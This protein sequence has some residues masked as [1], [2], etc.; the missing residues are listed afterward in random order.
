LGDDLGLARAWRRVASCHEVACRFRAAEEA[1]ERALVHAR[2][3]GSMQE[4]A[5]TIDLL[6]T[7][8]VFG[9][10][11]AEQAIARCETFLAE[12]GSPLLEANVLVALAVVRAMVGDFDQGRRLYERGEAIYRD[13]GLRLP[14]AGV[15][16]FGGL[17]ELLADDPIAAERHLRRGYEVF[18]DAGISKVL[19]FQAGLLAEALRRQDRREEAAQLMRT[20]GDTRSNDVLGGILAKIGRAHG[21]AYE[22]RHAKAVR[23]MRES[24]EVVNSTDALLFRGDAHLALA[25]TLILARQGDEA[26]VAAAEAA[27]LYREKGSVVAA[28]RA[29]RFF[30][31]HVPAV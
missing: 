5:R 21:E 25:E 26:A 14:L 7:N 28:A 6:C 30:A 31:E 23:L 13:L 8:L 3:A 4:Q 12:P 22:G 15:T 27:R 16:C 29:D 2:G 20:S 24:V 17:V 19:P 11:P 9:P 10:T 1:C 18:M